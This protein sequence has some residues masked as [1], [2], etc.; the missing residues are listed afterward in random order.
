MVLAPI[1][2]SPSTMV[3]TSS[4]RTTEPVVDYSKCTRCTI[5]W[6]FCPDVAI[7]L[8]LGSNY[9]SPSDRFKNLEAPLIDYDH[10]KGCGICAEECPFDAIKMVREGGVD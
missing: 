4:W 7:E 10:C 3:K 2:Y 6:K 1:A 8:V 9:D 5:C